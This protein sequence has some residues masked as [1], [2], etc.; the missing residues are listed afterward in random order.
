MCLEDKIFRD[1]VLKIEKSDLSMEKK[2]MAHFAEL[3]RLLT[4]AGIMPRPD[5]IVKMYSADAP[6]DVSEIHPLKT[7]NGDNAGDWVE[8]EQ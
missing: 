4:R 5:T 8:V 1:A 6:H 3:S 7:E 2:Y